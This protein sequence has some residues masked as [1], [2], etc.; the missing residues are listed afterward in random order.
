[1]S[2]IVP[3]VLLVVPLLAAVACAPGSPE[4]Q[5]A[6]IRAGYTI[7]LNSWQPVFEEEESAYA[8][9]LE[10]D[11]AAPGEEASAGDEAGEAAGDES[12]AG[13]EAVDDEMASAPQP[14]DILFDLVVYFKGR[15]SLPGVTVDITHASASQE[16]K[17]VYRQYIETPGIVNGETR[18]ADFVLEGLVV[19][20]GDAFAVEVAPGVPADLAAYREFS[21]TSL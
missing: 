21:E 8:S 5:I 4:E 2:P 19:Q 13:E 9:S 15:K 14:K 3:A 10:G 12:G 1:L 11:E 7:E 17:A 18:Q 6:E 16:E 20:E